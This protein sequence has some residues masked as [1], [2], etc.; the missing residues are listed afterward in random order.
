MKRFLL[1]VLA[2]SLIIS[3]CGCVQ[4]RFVTSTD[5]ETQ[6]P[7]D[8]GLA[9]DNT[10]DALDVDSNTDTGFIEGIENDSESNIES[11]IED[12]SSSE[13][14]TVDD[15]GR[16]TESDTVDDSES[17]TGADTVDDSERETE[18]DSGD[19][20]ESMS[21]LTDDSE[22]GSGSDTAD[23]SDGGESVEKLV[24]AKISGEKTRY[25]IIYSSGNRTLGRKIQNYLVRNDPGAGKNRDYYVLAYDGSTTDNGELE[26]LIGKTDREASRIAE[27]A[28]KNFNEF[29]ICVTGNKIAIYAYSD[30]VLSLAVE[31]FLEKIELNEDGELV[32]NGEEEIYVNAAF[33]VDS[34]GAKLL[35]VDL[36][37]FTIVIPANSDARIQNFAN[38]FRIH[39]GTRTGKALEIKTDDEAEN[40]YEILIGDTSRNSSSDAGGVQVGKYLIRLV[41]DE[42]GG[43]LVVL[44][45]GETEKIAKEVLFASICDGSIV[46]GED[47]SGVI[48]EDSMIVSSIGYLRDPCIILED[49]VYYAYGTRWKCF[50]NT[51]G[52]LDGAWEFL[53]VVVDIPEDAA[54]NYWAPE[55]HKYNGEYYM[56]TTYKSQATGHR[57]CVIMKSSTPEGPFKMITDGHITPK[58]WDAIDGTFYVDEEGQPWMVFVHEWTSMA[59]GVG[60]MAAAK[61][62]DDLTTF[63]SEPIELFKATDPS[64]AVGKITDGCWMYKCATG[65]LLMLWSNSDAYGYCV[66]VARSDNGR[67]D[68][69]WTQD[70]ELLYSKSMTGEFDGGHGMIFV[71]NRGQ[72]YLSI[73]SP[74]SSSAGREETPV[75]IEI[76]EE[77]GK[78][79]WV[80][81]PKK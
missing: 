33:D 45:D 25:R 18:S 3:F 15:S 2:V 30:E 43:K 78:L 65:E 21:D 56:F 67:I 80:D 52:R 60:R 32:Y 14:D 29:G 35:G 72:M 40:N 77:N 63:I 70:D 64:W 71:S 28:V 23:D 76:K 75:F 61:L 59:D 44:F 34:E 16:D 6:E 73:H 55:V 74:N 7:L 22:V 58:D 1:I 66:G 42:K 31:Y 11:E 38:E 9:A 48:K 37:Q 24:P 47:L 10:D 57:G 17:D 54:D 26:I 81:P 20:S 41:S 50:R 4:I 62:S 39:I 46:E 12:E 51:S 79:V 13:S 69:N 53:G 8:D 19:E 68:G 27:Q 5:D 49:G 36:S